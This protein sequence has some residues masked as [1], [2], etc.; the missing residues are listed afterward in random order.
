VVQRGKRFKKKKLVLYCNLKRTGSKLLNKALSHA[1]SVAY[2]YIHQKQLQ[3]I[4]KKIFSDNLAH[5]TH[6]ASITS[7]KMFM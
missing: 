1:K 6:T 3:E 5:N 2:L 7:I 4:F